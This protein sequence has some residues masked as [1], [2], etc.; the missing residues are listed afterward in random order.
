MNVPELTIGIPTYNGQMF[1]SEVLESVIREAKGKNVEVLVMD[2]ASVD[3]TAEI[4]MDYQSRHPEIV[5]YARNDKNV[6]FDGNVDSIAR[7]ATGRFVWFL[8]DDDYL[9]PGSVDHVLGIIR[10][11]PDLALIFANFSN[12]IDLGLS[13]DVYCQ[14]G[15]QF[16]KVDRFKNGLISSNIVNRKTWS[17][18]D[19]KRFDG[20]LWIHFAYAVQAMAPKEGRKAF[21]IAEELIRQGTTPRWGKGGSS[22]QV[23]LKLVQL[24]S[25]MEQ[26]GYWHET[27]RN[28]DLVI[29]GRYLREIPWAKVNGLKVDSELFGQMRRLYG[30]YPS[31]WLKDVPLLLI[32]GGF[33]RWIFN[34]IYAAKVRSNENGTAETSE[35]R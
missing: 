19:M 27:K 29:K 35:Y 22:L 8:A 21:V 17:D 20:C 12:W 11:N 32:P 1:L 16:F 4:A 7:Y 13:D 28:G 10:E 14:D 18:L 24:F 34:R 31:F 3:R 5:R 25:N 9:L 26:L 30:S 6:G 33:Y 23:G 15:N 2:N